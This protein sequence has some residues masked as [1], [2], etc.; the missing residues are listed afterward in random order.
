MYGDERHFQQYFRYIMKVSFIGGGNWSTR[1]KPQTC[2]KSLTNCITQC[3][4]DHTLPYVGLFVLTTLVVI[5]TDC[6]GIVVN[7]YDHDHDGPC[8]KE[9]FS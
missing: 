9:L 1:R 2:R 6:T 5:D 4:I 7:P 8:T 3:C